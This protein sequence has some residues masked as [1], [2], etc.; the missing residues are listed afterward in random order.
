MIN[1]LIIRGIL[2]L[3]LLALLVF[4]ISA[5]IPAGYYD[6]AS[7]KTGDELK[8]ALQGIIDN[9]LRRR[10]ARFISIGGVCQQ[11]Q[12]SSARKLSQFG[13]ISWPAIDRGGVKL[14]IP[15]MHDQTIWTGYS[16]SDTVG[17]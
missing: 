11:C 4:H 15:C 10:P 13:K 6:D 17:D 9:H 3:H 1:R 14:I 16:Q 7:G 12:H 5:Q 8:L 2:V